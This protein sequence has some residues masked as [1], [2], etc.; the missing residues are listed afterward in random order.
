MSQ[1]LDG[2]YS[3]FVEP[4]DSLI[5]TALIA[6]VLTVVIKFYGVKRWT[7]VD[8]ELS[9]EQLKLRRKKSM[10]QVVA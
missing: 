7:K 2:L 5:A 9:A 3:T 1:F 4:D 6:V 10:K 8:F